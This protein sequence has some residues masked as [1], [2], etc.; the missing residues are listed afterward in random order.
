MSYQT[1]SKR[2]PPFWILIGARKLVFFWHQS[3]ARTAATVWNWS[4]KTLSPGALLSVLYFTLCLI[5]PPVQTFP[6]LHYLP[7]GL[8]GWILRGRAETRLS[9]KSFAGF[10]RL[11]PLAKRSTCSKS[12]QR[13]EI[14]LRVLKNI[15]RVSPSFKLLCDEFKVTKC[16]K[17]DILSLLS[18]T[19]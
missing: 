18:V 17:K 16:C 3:E 15:S 11:A 9:K 8:R 10:T 19:Q 5:L 7:L 4:G 6:R 2:S 1:S 13:H 12:T 14:S